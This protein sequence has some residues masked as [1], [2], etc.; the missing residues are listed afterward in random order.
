MICSNNEQI[1]RKV[2]NPNGSKPPT[3]KI[4]LAWTRRCLLLLSALVLSACGTTP[5][6][7]SS[8]KPAATIPPTQQANKTAS[9]IKSGSPP[10]RFPAPGATTSEAP[11]ELTQF[12]EVPQQDPAKDLIAEGRYL[13][14]ALLLSDMAYVLPAPARQDYLL[15]VTSL[16]LQGNYIQQ[17][18]QILNSINI[19]NLPFSYVVHKS[20]L[21]SELDLA[22]QNPVAASKSLDKI[23]ANIASVPNNNQIE[24]YRARIDVNL[25]LSD[26]IG[27]AQAR[28]SLDYL[29]IDPDEKIEN[30]ETLLR[31]LQNV[32]PRELDRYK[33]GPVDPIMLGWLDLAK[34]AQQS[35]NEIEAQAQVD[36]WRMQHQNH[37][38]L[39][40][41]ISTL[42]TTQPEALG[43]PTH[44][45]LIL[46]MS[47]KFAKAATAI[48]DGFLA[49]YYSNATENQFHPRVSFYD[50]GDGS[51]ISAIYQRAIDEGADFV[52]GPLSKG[53]VTLLANSGVAT[54]G[55][56]TLNYGDEEKIERVPANF[57]QMSLS[58]EQEAVHVAEHAW[59]DGHTNAAAI[60]PKT[61]WGS[62]VYAAFRDRWEELG[63]IV[64]TNQTYDTKKSDYKIPIKQ[65]LNLDESDA[66][67]ST[68][69]RTVKQSLKFEP[70]RRKDVDFIFMA[71]F[72]K[73]GRLL[74][75]QLKF[76]R[77]TE[78]PVYATSHVYS[79][80]LKPQMDSDMNGVR[81]SDMPWTLKNNSRN[82][83]LKKEIAKLWPARGR[84]TRLYALG[85]D[86]YQILPELNRMR[87]NRFATYQGETGVLF[88]DVA[89]RLQRKL[90]W[91]QFN[92]GR[93]KILAEF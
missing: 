73:Q 68:I 92:R 3:R 85:V 51:Q 26:Y 7:P 2:K 59:L 39:P 40:T 22:K 17:A 93:P 8:A 67:F 74:R 77:A 89:N 57:F 38:V 65:L 15:R 25:G 50:E 43:R 78:I 37:P 30:Q 1:V 41:I 10:A 5:E 61:S 60:Y 11:L 14:A 4:A 84:F 55:V 53:S 16:L 70:R 6:R 64:V 13:D 45:A 33:R 90:L 19:E 63:G 80:R 82:N 35:Q 28:A 44:I 9:Q 79:G 12:S 87:R 69:R 75:P 76:H 23:Q 91:A 52:V 66:R 18:D 62:R 56:L 21:Q 34:I 46:P 88:L 31:D 20:I 72:A 24:Y 54:N 49:A 81:F 42:V 47:G 71:A 83:R 32:S 29:L 36:T 48:R 58:P 86:A 27:S